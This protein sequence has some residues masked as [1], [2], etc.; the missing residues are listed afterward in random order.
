MDIVV[1]TNNKGKLKEISQILSDYNVLG[2]N[3]VGA[4]VDVDETGVTYE[5]NALLKA[6]G[7]RP[8][9]D[10][11]I[12]SDDSGLEVDFLDGA[13]GLYS[14]RYAGL[15]NSPD[16]CMDKLLEVLK[17]VPKE[18]RGAKFVSCVLLL[19][20][21][22]TYKSFYGKCEGEILN[23]KRGTNGFGYDPVFYV[24][25]KGKTFS[26]MSDDEKNEI[27]HR[28]KALEKLKEYLK[29]EASK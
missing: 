12:I 26:E 6:N 2:Q 7:V 24:E 21:D 10:K 13:P 8:F 28:R 22:G 9:C 17:D 20:P 15:G 16:N 18:K 23:E 14:S 25:E 5:E 11:L 29:S 3:E 1:A 4:F 27:S 19:Y